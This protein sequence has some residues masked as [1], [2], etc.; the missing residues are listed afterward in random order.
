MIEVTG[1]SFHRADFD[2]GNPAEAVRR[3][4][5]LFPGASVETVG[6]RVFIGMCEACGRPIFEGEPYEVD[7]AVY[8][9]G[10]CCGACSEVRAETD[11]LFAASG[12]R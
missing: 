11:E 6:A 10:A 2:T 12:G 7:E 4:L 3:F 1:Q 5:A 9:C 8:L